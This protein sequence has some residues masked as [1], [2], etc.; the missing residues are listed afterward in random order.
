MLNPSHITDKGY[1]FQK[2]SEGEVSF[3]RPVKK[4]GYTLVR[5]YFDPIDGIYK[6][7]RFPVDDEHSQ[8][9]I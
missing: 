6:V 4:P 5:G 3:S 2:A 9:K 8:N 7:D 1:S